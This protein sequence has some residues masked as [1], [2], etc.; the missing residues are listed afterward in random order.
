M[1]SVPV[2]VGER[3]FVPT[4]SA[5]G[6]VFNPS[7]GEEIARVPMCGVAEVEVAVQAAAAAFT[8]WSM[9]A[10]PAR[11][12]RCSRSRRSSKRTSRNSRH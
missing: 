4:V 12:R 6:P 1:M 5:W 2:L 9:T 11:R 10:A 7:L 3:W 8:T